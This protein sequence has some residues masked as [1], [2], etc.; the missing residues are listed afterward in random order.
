MAASVATP[1]TSEIRSG[2]LINSSTT[3]TGLYG[4][5]LS[6]WIKGMLQF[7]TDHSHGYLSFGDGY[8]TQLTVGVIVAAMAIRGWLHMRSIRKTDAQ[9]TSESPVG[10]V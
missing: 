3:K 5:L 8:E 7:I 6:P 10:E 9:P 1:S 2:D 4:M